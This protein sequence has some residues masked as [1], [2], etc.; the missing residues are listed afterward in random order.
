MPFFAP[1]VTTE[2]D[3]LFTFIE[4]QAGQLRLTALDLSDEQARSTPTT[5]RLS[6]A[7]LI[8]H[9]AQVI[10]GWL[11]QV[12]DPD[13]VFSLDDYVSFGRAI[14]I[15]EMCDGAELPDLT[16]AE[17]LSAFDTATAEVTAAREL[18]D[19]GRVDLDSTVPV[20]DMPWYPK[21]FVMTVRWILNHI[22]TELARHAGHADIIRESI[23]GAIAYELNARA[24]GESWPP[25][26]WT[27]SADASTA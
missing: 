6:I 22:S 8:A 14:G 9:S 20:P 1:S 26:N 11:Q 16:L 15:E 13:R 25:E 2:S 7:G 4:Q 10:Y 5:S 19:S 3:A 23:D 12:K 18:V 24:A 17:L 27:D 21:D